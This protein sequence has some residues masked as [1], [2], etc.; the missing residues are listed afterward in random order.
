MSQHEPLLTVVIETSD[1]LDKESTLYRRLM[2]ARLRWEDSFAISVIDCP[3]TTA[4]I[5]EIC[6]ARP[7]KYIVFIK[8]NH[9]LSA[10]YLTTVLKFIEPRTVYLAEPRMYSGTLPEKIRK[11]NNAFTDAYNRDTDIY[12]TVFNTGRL[13]DVLDAIADIPRSSIYVAY[14]LY[15]SINDV[16]PLGTGYSV[17]S[18]TKSA[19][20]LVTE[21]NHDRLIPLIPTGSPTMRLHILRL[22]I[23]FLRGLRETEITGVS[24]NHLRDI[25]GAYQLTKRLDYAEVMHPFECAWIK[26]LSDPSDQQQ[27]F[28]R[29]SKHDAIL[30]FGCDSGNPDPDIELH[31]IDFSDDTVT[32][33]KSYRSREQGEAQSPEVYDFYSRPITETSSIIFFDRPMQADDNAEYLY[34][35]FTERHP[36]FTNV[37]FALN[38]KSPD[39][40]RLSARGF[41]LV[42]IFTHEFYEL[43]LRSD[44]VVSSQ[45]FNLRYKGKTLANSRFVYLQHGIQLNDMTNW[46]NSKYFDIFVATGIV[47]AE[48]LSK[49]APLEVI[50]S[51]LPRLE[52]LESHSSHSNT[53]L[54]M[55]TWRFNLHHVSAE[56]F[57]E[58]EYFRA[59]NSLLSDKRLLS[60]LERTDRQLLVKLHP[61]IE[62]R[63]GAF[64]FSDR[65]IKSDLSYRDAIS[66][67]EFVF[68]DYSSA[69]LDASFAGIPIAYYQWDVE[70]FFLEQP[71]ESRLDYRKEGLGPV[72]DD[73]GDL[74]NYLVNERYLLPYPEMDARREM[75]FAGVDSDR[76][77]DTIIDRMLSL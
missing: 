4:R 23:L 7:S 74:I 5:S 6:A 55:P 53:L 27:F 60:F 44:L 17:A 28:K 12:G 68:T 40:D 51:G 16:T 56:Q 54:F 31:R 33:G 43:F 35:H 45:I 73:H 37:Y 34:A 20:G 3:L 49:V 52:T 38:P 71:Y 15:W 77:N 75:F 24:L 66:A 18:V 1:A 48:Y 69:V 63:A 19:I 26:W 11:P 47:E 62:K 42:P 30:E 41:K 36:E 2:S 14:R 64:Q 65:V 25:V 8:Q 50:N 21:P 58:S 59:I 57:R 29:L 32:V 10:T 67:A 72:F 76:I 70:D 46:V 39:W 61:N 22:L 9:Q 13:A